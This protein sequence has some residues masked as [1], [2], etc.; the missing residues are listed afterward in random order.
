MKLTNE[1]QVRPAIE[2]P[3]DTSIHWKGHR[4]SLHSGIVKQ[5]NALEDTRRNAR[6]LLGGGSLT[7]SIVD[8]EIQVQKNGKDGGSARGPTI[9]WPAS[10]LQTDFP[11]TT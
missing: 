3:L 1:R 7:V 10:H 4:F 8:G 6:A 9:K 5:S 2:V 11:S